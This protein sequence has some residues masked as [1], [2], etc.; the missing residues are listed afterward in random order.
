M[1]L[2]K[3]VPLGLLV[4]LAAGGPVRAQSFKWWQ[5]EKFKNE[6]ALTPEQSAKIEEIFQTTFPKLR[7]SMKELD[8]L[9]TQ[10]SNL[11]SES[12]IAEAE[13][14]RQIDVVEAARSEMGK[15]RALMLFRIRQILSPEQ[16]EK[17]NA[18]HQKPE[19]ARKKT[20]S[21]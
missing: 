7:A 2:A 15:T 13:V 16:R 6:L 19:H 10:L 8:R 17:L 4:M 1:K 14:I 9:E 21:D 11:M 3:V 12:D 18:L 5:N 20:G